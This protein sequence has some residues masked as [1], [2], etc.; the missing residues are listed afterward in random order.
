MIHTHTMT[1]LKTVQEPMKLLAPG[2]AAVDNL[3]VGT[4]YSINVPSATAPATPTSNPSLVVFPNTSL[5]YLKIVP[6]FKTGTTSPK[7]RVTGWSRA[8]NNTGATIYYVPQ[9]LFEGSITLDSINAVT[10]NGDNTFRVA[11]TIAK[12]FGD[13]KIFNASTVNDTAFVLVDSLGCELIEIEFVAGSAVAD[14]ANAFVGA[15]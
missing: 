7:M 5:N 13:G 11:V 10:I 15:I 6:V 3:H 9:C 1:Q 12:N 4:A 14:A 2:S 8:V